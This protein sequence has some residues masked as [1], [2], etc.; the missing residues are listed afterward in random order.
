MFKIKKSVYFVVLL[1]IITA[2]LSA[3]FAKNQP[4]FS[5]PFA[6][7]S[8]AERT[9]GLASDVVDGAKKVVKDSL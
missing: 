5:N 9:K 7:Q 8:L 1:L 2:W 6:E 4:L 3:N